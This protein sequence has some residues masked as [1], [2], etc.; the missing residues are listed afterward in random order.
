LWVLA[1]G[2][3]RVLENPERI[4]ALL[5]TA[6][7]LGASDLFVQ[8]YRGGRAW[9]DSSA[10]DAGPY[11]ALLEKTGVDTLAQL[12][13]AAHEADLRVHAWVNVLSLA[14]NR[15]APIVR[16]LGRQSVMVDRVGRSVLDY[17]KLDLPEPDRRFVRMGTP[18][19]WLDPAAPGVTDRLAFIFGELLT[20]YP[21][22]D[23]LHL[24]YIRYP[25][26]LPFAPGSR[27]GVGMDFGYGAATRA[28]FRAE[29]GL[30]SPFGDSLANAN[31]W[32][33]W[34]RDQ[35]TGLV[36]TVRIAARTAHPGV[37]LSAA[38]WAW[39][40]RAYLSLGQDWRRWLEDGLLEFAVPMAYTL[41]DRILRYQTAAFA[42]LPT[43]NRI[44]IGLGTWLFAK[45]PER[46]LEQIRIAEESGA[47]GDALFSWDSIA[48]TPA[49]EAALGPQ[50]IEAIP[51][52][53]PI[54]AVPGE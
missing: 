36:A 43:S 41:D 28:R 48:D 12:I 17:P 42:G 5:E 2:S 13:T 53:Q 50:M 30:E 16:D 37:A 19:V 24:D 9:F 27:F 52:P 15:D 31:R 32:D 25:D 3:Q 14:S 23:G 45:R 39:A 44:W 20:R 51:E 22:L 29:T 49:L 11:R 4:P 54:E 21:E 34:R 35:V 6:R 1:E 26:V 10:A 33:D 38:V 47:A 46:A 7:S 18:A 8:V 40:D